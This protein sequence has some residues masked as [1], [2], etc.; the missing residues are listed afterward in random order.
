[1]L[2]SE[3]LK[4]KFDHDSIQ[5]KCTTKNN[6]SARSVLKSRQTQKN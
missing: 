3:R 4:G 5:Y 1:M 6:Y 2:N